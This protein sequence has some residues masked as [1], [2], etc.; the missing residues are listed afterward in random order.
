MKT[1]VERLKK[2]LSF[3][4]LQAAVALFDALQQGS[5]IITVKDISDQMG[6]SRSVIAHTQSILEA[7][8]VIETRSLG[9]KG[10]YIEIIDEVAFKEVADY[11]RRI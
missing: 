5:K 1:V 10:T 9:M 6:V 4:N 11:G 3:T 2:V 7:A 8:G